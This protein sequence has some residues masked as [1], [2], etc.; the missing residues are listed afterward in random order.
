M[1]AQVHALLEREQIAHAVIGAA[2]QAV[3]GV[4]RSTLDLDLLVL[5]DRVLVPAMWSPL[6][7]RGCH[8]EV[9][10]GDEI[11]PLLGVVRISET[12]AASIDVIVARASWARGVLDRATP[13]SIA[14]VSLP[15]ATAAD[16][17]LLKLFAGGPQDAWDVDQLLDVDP[18]LAE[19]VESRIGVLP[20]RGQ[21]LWKRILSERG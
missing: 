15:V 12:A 5:D 18:T 20:A 7:S 3:R 14:G 4:A 21:R 10:H 6:R 16:L 8:V 19:E 17:V 13:E 2:A 11:D 1:L 9:R